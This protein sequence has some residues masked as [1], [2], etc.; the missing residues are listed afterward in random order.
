MTHI[1]TFGSTM[2]W[3]AL[4]FPLFSSH[5]YG[6]PQFD[7]CGVLHEKISK[8]NHLLSLDE[9][10]YYQEK[11]NGISLKYDLNK[12][13]E[14]S[15]FERWVLQRDEDQNV[16]LAYLEPALF[17]KHRIPPNTKITK[18]NDR[19]VSTLDDEV[20]I[21]LISK[22]VEIEF[23]KPFT[24]RKINLSPEARKRLHVLVNFE[25]REIDTIDSKLS[26]YNVNFLH[27]LVWIDDRITSLARETFNEALHATKPENAPTEN[28][29]ESGFFCSFTEREFQS[30]GIFE[31][32]III[33]NAV[34]LE[35]D[36]TK[37]IYEME[38][39][40]KTSS[41]DEDYLE[42]RKEV[43]GIGTF[44]SNF[45]F[46]AFPFDSQKLAFSFQVNQNQLSITH[47]VIP[48]F[49]AYTAEELTRGFTNLRM[50]EWEP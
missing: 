21:E 15:R 50:Q 43:D 12:S 19:P 9:T 47:F 26:R 33:S 27:T 40:A 31:P 17:K 25:T 2:K 32:D 20:I 13:V 1:K 36:A 45:N 49:S 48:F 41:E 28:T 38:F 7:E 3:L 42:I 39:Y 10:Y 5:V 29:S 37:T 35:G 4:V 24:S 8:N 11:D 18:L 46:G 23:G 44:K 14:E 16:F 22:P 30:L 34:S 6:L